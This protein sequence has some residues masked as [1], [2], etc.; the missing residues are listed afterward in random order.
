MATPEEILKKLQPLEPI[1]STVTAGGFDINETVNNL[2][3]IDPTV[4]RSG[5]KN[6][7]FRLQLAAMDSREEQVQFL[8]DKVGEEGFTRDRF[9]HLALTP[10]GLKKI[11]LSGD[12]PTLIDEPGLSP[13]DLVEILPSAP[14]VVG[15]ILGG[16]AGSSTGSPVI[17]AEL[18]GLGAAAGRG[19]GETIEDKLGL[20]YQPQEEVFKQ[21]ALEVPL[22]AAGEGVAQGLGAAGRKLLAPEAKRMT[23]VS[24][25][26]VKESEQIG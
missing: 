18:A 21:T 24:R 19:I 2:R 15:G 9:G 14:A 8:T 5:V 17:A 20:N 7:K 11:G 25:Q 6:Y 26:L 13:Q 4:D 23:D 22:A 1:K 10:I 16:V 3:G 12:R